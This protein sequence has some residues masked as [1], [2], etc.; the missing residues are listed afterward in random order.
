MEDKK[1]KQVAKKS[2]SEQRFIKDIVEETKNDFINR[3]NARKTF[4]RQWELNMNFLIGNQYCDI[5]VNGEIAEQYED[6]YWQKRRVFNHIAPLI[7]SRLSKLARINPEIKVKP[8]SDDDDDVSKAYV[9]EKLIEGAFSNSDLQKVVKEATSWS[10]TCGTAFYK[11]IWNN[12]GGSFLGQVEGKD[13]YEGDAEII[14]VSPFE[15][16]PDNLYTEKTEDLRSII[17]AK[18]VSVDTVKE[19]YGVSVIG[20]AIDVFGLEPNGKLNANGKK[21]MN[22][23]VIVIEKYERP[24]E[25]FPNGRLITVAGDKLLYYGDLPYKNGKNKERRFPFIKQVSNKIPG[26]FFGSS[27]IERLIPVQRA[28]NAVK[29]RKHEFM[30]RLS[31]G[32]LTVEDGSVDVDDIAEE[33][34]NP[35]KVLV[36]RQGSKAPEIMEEGAIPPDFN[37]EENKLIQEFVTISGVS[38]VSSSSSNAH[39]SSASALELLIEQD[40]QRLVMVAETI[41]NGYIE[42]AKQVLRLYSQFIVGVKAVKYNDTFNKTKVC[43][44][45]GSS[46]DSDDVY[47]ENEN[48]L[49]FTPKQRKETILKLYESGLLSDGDKTIRS[50]IK[51][52]V[53]SLLG[54]QDLDYLKGLNRLQ[55]EKA[56]NE[57]VKIRNAGL[58][59]EEIDD[60]SIHI[61]EHTRY[62]LSEYDELTAK[63]KTRLFSHIRA[64]KERL[65]DIAMQ[66]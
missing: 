5:G 35:G 64:H 26:C 42:I 2:E 51:A 33:G 60:D 10:E 66:N 3:R 45:D 8:K 38:D 32:I 39:L 47:I 25:E 27:I 30:N 18:A 21:V 52:K 24:S 16:F 4:E 37:D 46:A 62:V 43:Y 12:N 15:I 20:E 22:N 61:D 29:N 58:S 13:V 48:E 54:Y 6:Y 53:L 31:S 23:A 56:Q 41:R 50:T 9:A 19:K 1:T 17:H 55:E 14:C 34:L 44:A 65:N 36:Y 63:E 59:I 57:N 7:E 40:N 49:T 11:V 28:F